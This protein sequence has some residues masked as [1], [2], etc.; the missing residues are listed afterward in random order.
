MASRAGQKCAVFTAGTHVFAAGDL[1]FC[2]RSSA[3]KRQVWRH[4]T[5]G[6]LLQFTAAGPI[7]LQQVFFYF[8][9]NNMHYF[10]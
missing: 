9:G 8:F 3:I 1:P 6:H 2:S 4:K 5:A 7:F 10:F